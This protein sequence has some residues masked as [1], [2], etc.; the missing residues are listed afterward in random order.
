MRRWCRR[1]SQLVLS[2]TLAC[3]CVLAFLAAA[4]V[5]G[6]STAAATTEAWSAQ[7]SPSSAAALGQNPTDR[8]IV[9]LRN[10]ETGTYGVSR[11]SER[12]V[13]LR[14][15]ESPIV[16]ELRGV[17]APRIM[18]YSIVGAVAA[19]VS[20][21]EAAYLASDPAVQA[22]VP[23]EI[24]RGPSTDD[25]LLGGLGTGAGAQGITQGAAAAAGAAPTVGGG[26]ATCPAAGA[27]P[28]VE[29]EAL[30][31]INAYNS[32]P[33]VTTAQSLGYTGAGVKIAVF[34]DGMDPTLP[35]FQRSNGHGGTESAITDYQ[36]F[37]GDGINAVTGGGEAFGDVSSLVAQ[38]TTVYN[39]DQEINPAFA[40]TASG[41]SC[42]I[43]VL[44]VS[45]GADVDVMKVFGNTGYAFDSTILEGIDY[46]VSVDHVNILSESF[47]ED[48]I[49]NPANDPISLMNEQA[50]EDGITVIASTG[51]ASPS[52]S[53]GEPALDPWVIGAAA[54][55]SYQLDAQTNLF[56]YDMAQVIKQGHGPA[57]YT[58]G[59]ATPGWLDDQ[60]STLSSSGF[61]GILRTPDI[62]A[63]GDDNWASCSTD[64]TEYTDCANG[65]GGSTIGL[66]DFGGTSESAP[67]TAGTAA[68][69]IQA[70]REAHNNATPTP[71]VVR[72]II[73]SA[74]TD[75]D[76][77]GDEMGAG[78]LN[79]VRAVELAKAWDTTSSTGGL[80]HTPNYISALGAPG[81]VHTNT[82]SV[83][84]SSK[85]SQTVTP[86]LRTLGPA[87]TLSS[88][89]MT[90]SDTAGSTSSCD[91][92]SSATY[93]TG[94]TID[95]INC[96][97][98]IVPPAID[99][100]DSRIAW[101]PTET[102]STCGTGL[103]PTVREILVDP[104]GRFAQY[105]DPQGD[106]A[107][108]ADEQVHNP[109]AGKWTL[110]IYAR[111]TSAY[112]GPVNYSVT[113]ATYVNVAGAISP[114]S[115]ALAPGASAT[116]TANVT[117]PSSPGDWTGSIY[118][119]SSDR[120]TSDAGTIPVVARAEVPVSNGRPGRF[121]GV[122]IGGNGRPNAF[123]DELTYQFVVPAGE[124]SVQVNLSVPNAGYL[125]I[126]QLDDPNNSPVDSEYDYYS[127]SASGSPGIGNNLT[128]TWANPMP[129]TWSLQVANVLLPA[130]GEFS[131]L[132]AEPLFGS[133]TFNAVRVGSFGVPVSAQL[134]PGSQVNAL[135]TVTNT[136]T[137]PED[138]V[139]D[140]RQTTSATYNSVS[141]TVTSGT[142]PITPLN[143]YPQY[144]VPPLSSSLSIS[145]ST[146]GPVPIDFAVSPDWGS[147]EY[148]SS[149]SQGATPAS[150]TIANPAASSW[151]FGPTEVGVF[152]TT[153]APSEPYTSAAQVNTLAF[154]P[155]VSSSTSDPWDPTVGL[156]ESAFQ[157]LFLLPGQTGTIQVTFT[158]PASA[159]TGS[160]DS[161]DVWVETF[162]PYLTGD[163]LFSSDVLT[164]IPYSWTVAP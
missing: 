59:Q 111:T 26:Y 123:G 131:G 89:N 66:E 108:F 103:Y 72:E 109:A 149:T 5:S 3:G 51:D 27:P 97:S 12:A 23:D 151:G 129:G 20:P 61:T 126:G 22:V 91:G 74:A 86:V 9:F 15:D 88:G 24:V 144:L 163:L 146:S 42:D 84:N 40:N 83:T 46:A 118:F 32:D 53:E 77:P 11:E 78:L 1:G 125:L 139:V 160:T 25:N 55:T 39:L 150:V 56:L 31:L 44:G 69:V 159:T 7:L 113:G 132:T 137:E 14:S 156:T 138:Y 19:T 110:L 48:D 128:L 8:V 57:S 50:V 41:A 45:P 67:L 62:I 37:S 117:T 105:S 154:D 47:G 121:T 95:L 65:F 35:N 161:G 133:I 43:R 29:P 135:V 64:T 71:A 147:P 87:Q 52:N 79:A 122:L 157:P 18:Q 28:L 140:P 120:A 152:T 34:P 54:S 4:L 100:L 155:D 106:G 36:D 158:V 75:I 16:Q 90:L 134:P 2:H 153:P 10:Q 30:S 136:G 38:G 127:T 114:A 85:T 119:D 142:L 99:Q 63:P 116:F 21:A 102:C 101:N 112:T 70:Y 33:S 143:I 80:V 93:Y 145:S 60:V 76:V 164:A 82:V 81:S 115:A 104:A 6:S 162:N 68:L 107:G 49:P 13:A 124:K 94:E 73:E 130:N 148:L 96:T 98:F 141:A 17:R 92:V 58:L